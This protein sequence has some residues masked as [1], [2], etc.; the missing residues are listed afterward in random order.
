MAGASLARRFLEWLM[1]REAVKRAGA[2]GVAISQ[3]RAAMLK[4]AQSYADA[5]D[6]AFDADDQVP[7]APV[8]TLYREAIFLLLARD[9]AGKRRL[10]VAFENAPQAIL[11]DAADC[12]PNFA[13]LRHVL[14]LHASLVMGDAPIPEI[15]SCA[16][17]TR[18]SLRAVL[19]RADTS[20]LRMVLRIRARRVGFVAAVLLVVL[21]SVIGLGVRLCAPR[22]LADGQPWRASSTLADAF[23][24]KVLFHTREEVSPWFEIDLGRVKSVRRL[25]VKNRTDCCQ[26]RAIPLAAEVSSDRSNWQQVARTDAPF[27]L[28]E[29]SFPPVDARYVRLR[30]ARF[31][32]FHLEQVKVF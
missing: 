21:M 3:D 24:A 22:D 13:R 23:S 12:D 30:V 31:T 7:L 18:T 32:M 11:G 9:L 8:L 6:T 16:E 4:A 17:I 26:E 20:R 5:A 28:W 27:L 29:P 2:D 19:D 25:Y 1:M 15:R 14:A 10:A